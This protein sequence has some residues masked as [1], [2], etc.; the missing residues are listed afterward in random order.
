MMFLIRRHLVSVEL[1]AYKARMAGPSLGEP[2]TG[3]ARSRR[4][5]FRLPWRKA[6]KGPESQ[7][8]ERVEEATPSEQ[9]A[10]PNEAPA[11][12]SET[13]EDPA[14]ERVESDDQDY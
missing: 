5:I 9:V 1:N 12:P 6:S 13:I 7:P 11:E 14:Q 8:R 10:E 4:S 3:A 2:S